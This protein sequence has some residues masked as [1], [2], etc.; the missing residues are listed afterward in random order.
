MAFPFFAGTTILAVWQYLFRLKRS[1]SRRSLNFCSKM[2]HHKRICVRELRYTLW[3]HKSVIGY[4]LTIVMRAFVWV[5]IKGTSKV[6]VTFHCRGR[7]LYIW[8]CGRKYEV[9]RRCMMYHWWMKGRKVQFERH[10][11]YFNY[12]R[13]ANER[14]LLYTH[15]KIRNRGKPPESVIRMVYGLLWLTVSLKSFMSATGKAV[16]PPSST[17]FK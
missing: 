2:K 5:L 4:H 10:R 16:S 7:K 14:L 1:P 11:L 3:C 8:L 9:W 6:P 17:S 15:V 13:K 12:A